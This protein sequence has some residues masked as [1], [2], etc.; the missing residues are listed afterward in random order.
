MSCISVQG[1]AAGSVG[2]CSRRR[3][4]WKVQDGV[5]RDL[6]VRVPVEGFGCST[7]LTW[8]WR[9]GNSERLGVVRS[10]GEEGGEDGDGGVFG[11]LLEPIAPRQPR[12]PDSSLY[13]KDFAPTMVGERIFS[14]WDMACLWIGLVVG[15]PTY[16]MAGSL[17][18]MGMSWWEGILTVLIGNLVVLVPMVLSGHAGTK[19]GV[20]FPVLA[21]AAFG[22]RGAN[23]P[24]LLRALVACGWFGIQ[25]WIGGQAIFQLLNTLVRGSLTGSAVPWLGISAAEFGCFLVFWLLQI[26]IIWNGI[27]SIRELEKVSAPILILLS[28]ALL[29]WAYVQAG[30][31]GPML[32]LPSQFIAGGPK[33][34][35]F[36]QTFFPALTANVGFWATLSLNIPDFTRYSKSQVD[37]LTGQAIGLPLFMAAF[38]FVG[39]AVTSATVVIFGQA[40][41]DPIQ[42]LARIDGFFPILLSLVG[43]IL[44]TLTTNI[45]ANVVAPANALVNLSPAIFSFR[46]GGLL[47][48]LIGILLQPWRLIQS[49]Q[50][51]IFTWLIGYSAL[52]GPVGGIML[53]DYFGL[54]GRALDTD[55]LFSSDKQGLYWY[56][57]GYNLAAL[58]SLAAGILPNIP[59]FLASTGVLPNC[60]VVFTA[61]YSNAWFVGFMIAG[62]VYRTLS[63]GKYQN[64][65][66]AEA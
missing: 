51:F 6:K 62:L 53:V 66:A 39:L 44:A 14:V 15:V 1:I 19:F 36:W 10:G 42:L 12:D 23:V 13:N 47:T 9:G 41:S 58:V 54:R 26:G 18:E 43:V 21:R 61:I 38:T 40:I 49:S 45:A 11:G 25:T 57:N 17:V 63:R 7:G 48:A 32:S 4:L 65:Q 35:Q 64:L 28:A 56:S 55:A 30:G 34:G 37:Q 8:G 46:T 27:E 20:P 59:G 50:G 5:G 60:P 22:I 52:L 24:S 33:A 2:L 3:V 31:F 29:A 16:Y